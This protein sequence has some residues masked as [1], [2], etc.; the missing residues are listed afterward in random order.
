V[1]A[2]DDERDELD[3]LRR[4]RRTRQAPPWAAERY[5]DALRAATA[6][7]HHG[8]VTIALPVSAPAPWTPTGTAVGAG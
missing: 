8:R 3:R 5:R 4:A 7:G 2:P 1:T 6:A